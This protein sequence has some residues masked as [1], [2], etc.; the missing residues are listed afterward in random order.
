M[1]SRLVKGAGT[2]GAS[3]RLH[4]S[5]CLPV[6][7][8]SGHEERSMPPSGAA[9]CGQAIFGVPN[10]EFVRSMSEVRDSNCV[11]SC[12]Q[13]GGQGGGCTGCAF[14]SIPGSEYG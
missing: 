3:V 6:C 13:G 11:Q 14:G 5:L 10:D 8:L 9:H 2:A 1:E 4:K 12:T 7:A